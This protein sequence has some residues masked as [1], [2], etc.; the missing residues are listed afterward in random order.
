MFREKRHTLKFKSPEP[1]VVQGTNGN[2]LHGHAKGRMC[3]EEKKMNRL[4][5]LIPVNAAGSSVSN[6]HLAAIR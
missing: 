4:C 1:S 6:S 3:S 5:L 2:S